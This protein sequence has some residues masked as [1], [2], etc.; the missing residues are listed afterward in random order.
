MDLNGL[1]NGDFVRIY[2]LRLIVDALILVRYAAVRDVNVVRF[3][4]YADNETYVVQ[5][6]VFPSHLDWK[7]A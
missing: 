2:Y 1:A 6:G 3:P 5:E 7:Q 4:V